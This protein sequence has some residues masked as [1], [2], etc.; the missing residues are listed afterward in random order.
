MKEFKVLLL[1]LEEKD[2]E[3]IKPSFI[4]AF[5][6]DKVLLQ[7]KRREEEREGENYYHPII[8]LFLRVIP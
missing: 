5:F 4:R 6:G 7:K 1:G 3:S 2:V 8:L